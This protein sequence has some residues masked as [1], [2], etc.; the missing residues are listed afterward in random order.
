MLFGREQEQLVQAAAALSREHAP[1]EAVRE[2]LLLVVPLILSLSRPPHAALEQW[3][4]RCS[5][6]LGDKGYLTCYGLRQ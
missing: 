5:N 3:G 2:W 4:D 6:G 1:L